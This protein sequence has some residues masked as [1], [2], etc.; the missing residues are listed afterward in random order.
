MRIIVLMKPVPDTYGRPRLDSDTGL[1]DRSDAEMVLD[2]I[3]ERALEAA[4]SIAESREGVE[5]VA[6]SMSPSST[7]SVLRRALAIGATEAWQVADERLRGADIGLT[8]EVLAA[9]L[10]TIG[11]DLVLAGDMSS[12]AQGGVLPSALAELLEV[13]A[14]TALSSVSVTDNEITGT[15]PVEG[16]V[17][18]VAASLPAVVSITE[19]LPDA[20]FPNFKGIRA[21]KKR[22]LHSLT[23][24]DIGV[25]AADESAGRSI[26]VGLAE[27][28]PRA[29]G[30]RIVD[31]GDA[32]QRIAT[33]LADAGVLA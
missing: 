21:A 4:L 6:A 15:R 32:G 10:G 20:R 3:G 22:P 1:L 18:Q 19:A 9:L 2:E 27:R 23:L 13:P 5:V 8:A 31:A 14:A 24:D 11:Y 30:E 28:P 17:Q 25:D 33:Y 26:M 16:G 12:D 29:A 7:E